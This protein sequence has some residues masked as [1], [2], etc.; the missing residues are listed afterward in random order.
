M[1][2]H[3]RQAVEDACKQDGQEWVAR[4]FL[5]NLDEHKRKHPAFKPER[6]ADVFLRASSARMRAYYAYR[7]VAEFT[8]SIHKANSIRSLAAGQD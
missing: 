4:K 8:K 2:E 6:V 3:W 1:A 5:A 7:P